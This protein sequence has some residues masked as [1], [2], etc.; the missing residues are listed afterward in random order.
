MAVAIQLLLI[1]ICRA[2]VAASAKSA[3]VEPWRG[4]WQTDTSVEVVVFEACSEWKTVTNH[5]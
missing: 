5:E 4:H 3:A 2:H 1:V